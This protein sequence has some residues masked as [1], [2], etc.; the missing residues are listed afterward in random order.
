MRLVFLFATIF[1]I[2]TTIV[3]GQN[4]CPVNFGHKN[5]IEAQKNIKAWSGRIVAF[6]AK[7]LEVENGYQ[8][9]PYYK[10]EMDDGGQL[11]V[12]TL[13]TSGYE[14]IGK[15]LRILGYFSEVGNDEI[16]L[17]YNKNNFHILAFAVIDLESKQMS[18][19]P[20]AKR[21]VADWVEGKMP[22]AHKR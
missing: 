13:L 19:F 4:A 16:A 10:V 12:G 1:V 17:K 7:V 21:D 14:V 6:N 18:V 3:M 9:K 2:S 22:M 5:L 11:W 8:D 20:G 15:K